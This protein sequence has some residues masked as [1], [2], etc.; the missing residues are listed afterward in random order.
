MSF[1]MYNPRD[2]QIT[3]YYYYNKINL[4]FI[5][6]QYPHQFDPTVNSA[7]VGVHLREDD[8]P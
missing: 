5:D 2:Q 3:N 4:R 8:R 1:S 6:Y 7:F